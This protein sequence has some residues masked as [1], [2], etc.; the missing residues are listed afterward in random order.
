M[1]NRWQSSFTIDMF[2][3]FMHIYKHFEQ[4]INNLRQQSDTIRIQTQIRVKI[5]SIRE[6]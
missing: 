2:T 3:Y 1:L 4:Q 6:R 5:S